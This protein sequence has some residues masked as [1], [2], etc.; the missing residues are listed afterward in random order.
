V[1]ANGLEVLDALERQPYDVVLMDV[2]MPEMDGLE[3]TREVRRRWSGERDPRI[4]AMTAN[5]VQEDQE[6]CFAAGMDDYLGKP[7][8]VEELVRALSR[9]RPS[10]EQAAVRPTPQEP[11]AVSPAMPPVQVEPIDAGAEMAPTRDVPS[12][13]TLDQTALQTLLELVD[14]ERIL[15]AELIDSFLEETPPLLVE[16]RRSLEAGDAGGLRR[17]A[18]TL[19]SSSRDFGATRL[20]EWAQELEAMGK[21]GTLDGAQDLVTQIEV[22]YP[23]VQMALEAVRNG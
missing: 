5:V 8:R 7:I 22:E 11:R 9:C 4:I 19:K 23:Q 1:A 10:T 14:G 16:L 3:A 15:L 6:A 20:A 18:H 13:I 21:A 12:E 2:Q 17:S